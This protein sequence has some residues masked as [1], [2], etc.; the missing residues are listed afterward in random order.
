MRKVKIFFVWLIV[1]S[2]PIGLV[3][4]QNRTFFLEKREIGLDLFFVN[5]HTPD[6]PIAFF[7]LIVFF[8]G[9]LI[10][11]VSSLSQRYKA[12]KNIRKLT[13]EVGAEKK[14]NSELETKIES[15]QASHSR[16]DSTL[17]PGQAVVPEL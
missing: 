12:R 16:P 3:A 14:K 9:L 11:Y 10:S 17:S 4:Y 1:L 7:L 6:I 8:A 15:L 5:Y 2:I 13:A